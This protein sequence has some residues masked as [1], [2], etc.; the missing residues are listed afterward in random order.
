M[1][2]L[3]TSTSFLSFF[4]DALFLVLLLLSLDSMGG[5]TAKR[6]FLEETETS[7]E[8]CSV[9]LFR[10]IFFELLKLFRKARMSDT[11]GTTE[12]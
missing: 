12:R 5:D 11:K 3:A 7:S 8:G 1:F 6:R 2:S 9:M 4:N 10:E